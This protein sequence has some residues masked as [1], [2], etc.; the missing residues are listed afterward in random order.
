MEFNYDDDV[1]NYQARYYKNL[2]YSDEDILSI[3][4]DLPSADIEGGVTPQLVQQL[5]YNNNGGG[6]DGGGIPPGPPTDNEDDEYQGITGYDTLGNPISNYTS[7][8]S[9][10]KNSV[11]FIT[12]PLG[13]LGYQGYK[14]IQDTIAKKQ[15]QNFYNTTEA[16]TVQDMARDN[17]SSNTGGYQAGY[18]G[19]FMDGPS[20]AG[21]G[22]APS[23]KGGSDSMGS[24]AT[25]GRVGYLYGGIASLL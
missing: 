10:L 1:K 3:L 18:G 4:G 22:N 14:G 13:Y 21:R 17:K 9:A 7:P 2:G 25:G 6:D 12:N 8:F 15:L 20:G 19:G 24:F 11:A 23:D 5:G 16:K